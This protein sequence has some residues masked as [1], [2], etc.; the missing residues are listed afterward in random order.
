MYLLL[1]RGWS[2]LE[3][4]KEERSSKIRKLKEG[5]H[6]GEI[7]WYINVEHL[8]IQ[9]KSNPLNYYAVNWDYLMLDW[10]ESRF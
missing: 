9:S 2:I 6:F 7:S 3:R 1:R 5:D 10:T 4:W 8:K